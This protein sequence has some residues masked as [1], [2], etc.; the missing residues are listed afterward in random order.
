MQADHVGLRVEFVERDKT[1]GRA[2]K[3]R[4]DGVNYPAR[5]TIGKEKENVTC[6]TEREPDV[7]TMV[8]CSDG[9]AARRL[10]R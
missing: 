2:G 8:L 3:G 1:Q 7:Y 6:P 4:V 9:R 5:F 10:R